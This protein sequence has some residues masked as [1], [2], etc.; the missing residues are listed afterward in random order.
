MILNL[1]IIIKRINH[2]LDFMK[3]KIETKQFN[4]QYIKL[5]L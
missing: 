4:E 3:K 1:L 2:L 5:N